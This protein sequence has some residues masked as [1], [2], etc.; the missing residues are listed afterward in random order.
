MEKHYINDREIMENIVNFYKELYSDSKIPKEQVPD[1]EK[2]LC[3]KDATLDEIIKVNVD[4]CTGIWLGKERKF[5]SI[6][7]G[8]IFTKEPVKCL[9]LYFGGNEDE[10]YNLNWTKKL[11]HFDQVLERWK[12]RD[13]TLFGKIVI[14][15]NS[16]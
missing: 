5:I 15:K 14:F 4:K 11:E 8:I 9:G 7:E 2:G 10:M 12:E 1:N 6:F 3:D 13:F 16:G